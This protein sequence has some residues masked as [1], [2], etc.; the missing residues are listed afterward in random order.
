MELLP[1]SVTKRALKPFMQPSPL[2]VIVSNKI[3]GSED[4]AVHWH[5]W[6]MIWKSTGPFLKV[7]SFLI[8]RA[9]NI[10]ESQIVSPTAY[11]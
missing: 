3:T 6:C 2:W 5:H 7:N 4:R 1:S 10:G 8:G 9:R 11:G